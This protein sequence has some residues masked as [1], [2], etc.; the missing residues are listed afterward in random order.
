MTLAG[1]KL[2]KRTIKDA[3]TKR[4]RSRLNVSASSLSDGATVMSTLK[5]KS[6]YEVAPTNRAKLLRMENNSGMELND[7]SKSKEKA[8]GDTLD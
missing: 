3:M 2:I 5:R 6:G 8:A 4:H 7:D 1:L